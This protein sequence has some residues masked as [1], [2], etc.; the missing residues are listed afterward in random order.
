[1]P[2]IPTRIHALLDLAVAVLL[3]SAPWWGGFAGAN[4][5][6]FSA[7]ILGGVILA[8]NLATDHEFGRVRRLQMTVHLWLDAAA[9]L[10]A[11]AAPW[12]LGFDQR[13]WVPHLSAGVVLL[14]LAIV[15]QTIP[16]YERRGARA[17]AD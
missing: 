5:E 15:S 3:L 10:L 2:A 1:M 8:Y 17:G 13:V 7:V 12:V 16:G 14:V 6:T 9:G 11:A 4:A